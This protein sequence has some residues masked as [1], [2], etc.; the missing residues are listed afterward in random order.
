MR[1]FISWSGDRSSQV[2]RAVHDWI[3]ASFPGVDPWLSSDMQKGMSW[4][5]TLLESLLNS[6]IGIL[7]VTS[8][9]EHDWM[10][11]EAG[12]LL[13]AS[14][15]G[16]ILFSLLIDPDP[17]ALAASPINEFRSISADRTG[18][19]EL[20]RN[21]A[22]VGNTPT[23]PLE[24]LLNEL[25]AIGSARVRDFEISFV[26]PEGSAR[27]PLAP[28]CDMEWLP[29]VSGIVD[30][31]RRDG[32]AIGNHDFMSFHYLDLRK[33]AWIP[34]PKRIS[35]IAT[36]Q[37]AVVHQQY[38]EDWYGNAKI[39]AE[40]LKS[41]FQ[42][43]A[44][45]DARDRRD[46]LRP[47]SAFL[48]GFYLLQLPK[49]G[50]R[51]PQIAKLLTNIQELPGLPRSWTLEIPAQFLHK[52]DMKELENQLGRAPARVLHLVALGFSYASIFDGI[53]SVNISIPFDRLACVVIQ[54]RREMAEIDPPEEIS[55]PIF[56]VLDR[57]V[58][59]EHREML[60]KEWESLQHDMVGFIKWLQC[61]PPLG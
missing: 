48:Y 34:L 44:F 26:L 28:L 30:A 18:F 23:E 40:S 14:A 47:D 17:V 58:R 5:N 57:M 16:G 10:S 13:A 31:L 49:P 41:T 20:G 60:P 19:L 3:R 53:S 29:A 2:A 32:V 33:P 55:G 46:T 9:A 27:K 37:L 61:L 22:G 45:L 35:S 38:F 59:P 51:Q 25:E 21:L 42:Y 54:F 36:D 8:E 24:R 50:L 11:F 56:H 43:Q 15:S 12:A 7:C 39:A 6:T 4:S 52:P 1:V